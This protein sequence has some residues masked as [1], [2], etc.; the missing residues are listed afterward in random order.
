MGQMMK[1]PPSVHQ[2]E[3]SGGQFL[4]HDVMLADTEL[5]VDKRPVDR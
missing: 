3:L 1:Q 5:T 2:V 4:G